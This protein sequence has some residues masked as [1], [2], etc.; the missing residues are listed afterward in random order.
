M[1]LSD[2]TTLS[3]KKYGKCAPCMSKINQEINDG[4]IIFND[5]E[6]QFYRNRKMQIP[7]RIRRNLCI[8]DYAGFCI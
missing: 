7:I 6:F 2:V 8:I 3:V 5:S 1:Y 4:N